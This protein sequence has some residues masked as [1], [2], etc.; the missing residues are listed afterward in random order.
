M[1]S[2]PVRAKPIELS[3]T[4]DGE[5]E[6]EETVKA[7]SQGNGNAR[8][9]IIRSGNF[10]TPTCANGHKAGRAKD[11]T[12]ENSG[13][14]QGS[15]IKQDATVTRH[16]I[17]PLKERLSRTF[18]GDRLFTK[19]VT[20]DAS[21]VNVVRQTQSISDEKLRVP[22]AAA[23]NTARAVNRIRGGTVVVTSTADKAKRP[24]TQT[25]P[26]KIPSPKRRS[27][28]DTYFDRNVPFLLGARL[29]ARLCDEA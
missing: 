6:S 1:V 11:P 23:C 9:V 12:A 5:D 27:A 13:S 26:K 24:N 21:N 3:S 10:I 28:E 29:H 19:V 22:K 2:V 16:N 8:A 4:E 14:S 17:R 20:G 25:S 15:V 18:L 7:N